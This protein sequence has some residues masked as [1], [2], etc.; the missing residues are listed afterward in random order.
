MDIE[1]KCTVVFEKIWEAINSGKYKYIRVVGGSGSSKTFSIL[2]ALYI[3]GISRKNKRISVFRGTKE[4]CRKT[5]GEDARKYYATLPVKTFHKTTYTQLLHS[6]SYIEFTGTDDADIL[7]GY[8]TDLVWLN[9]PYDIP[10]SVFTE[11]DKRTEACVIIDANL[12]EDH[13]A[14]KLANR[15]DCCTIDCSFKDNPFIPE[16]RK[17]TILSYKPIKYSNLVKAKRLTELE[18][19]EYVVNKKKFSDEDFNDLILCQLNEQQGSA[20]EYQWI[21]Y[22]EGGRADRP[23]RIFHWTAITYEEFKKIDAEELVGIDWGVSDPFAIVLVKYKD[24]CLYVHELN[25]LSENEWMRNLALMGKKIDP[26]GG[27]LADMIL[28]NLGLPKKIK[29][30]CDSNY[31]EK[32]MSLRDAGW[33]NA[34]SVG[35][36]EKIVSSVGTLC[37]LKVFYTSMSTNIYKEQEAYER[38]TDRYNI[39]LET[40]VD[41]DNHTIDAIRYDVT[42]LKRMGIIKI[43]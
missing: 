21:V 5:V 10:E 33:D 15:P 3:W 34:M 27:G 30:I 26:D 18:A 11:L 8:N 20:N 12:K 6:N 39:V 13:W 22:G 29:I 2:Q 16:R 23:N 32:V 19:R 14:D 9:E 43:V 37:Q 36:K 1:F 4:S 42:Y 28:K 38:E 35:K 41:K 40:P 17:Q 24:A 25:Y 31:P 7:H